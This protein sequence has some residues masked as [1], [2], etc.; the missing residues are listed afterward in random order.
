MRITFEM[1]IMGGSN[2]T[3]AP[4][5]GNEFGTC[6]IEVLTN[7]NVTHEEWLGFMQEI[8]EEWDSL[9]DAQGNRLNV[10]SHWAKQWQGLRFRDMPIID[11]CKQVAYK[12]RIPEFKEGLQKIADGG[13]YSLS[14]IQRRFSNPVLDDIFENVFS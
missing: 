5:H 8:A 9:T 12:D 13:G 7:L 14:D 3:M 10:R 4:Q 6:S 11:H 2:I 1:R